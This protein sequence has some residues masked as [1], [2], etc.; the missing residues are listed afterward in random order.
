MSAGFMLHKSRRSK[1][2]KEESDEK[3]AKTRFFLSKL[4]VTSTADV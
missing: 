1:N 2:T 4:A 3:D